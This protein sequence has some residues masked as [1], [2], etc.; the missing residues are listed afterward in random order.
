MGYYPYKARL[1]ADPSS[2]YARANMTVGKVYT[3]RAAAG[4][5]VEVS[6]N[7]PGDYTII[8]PC[9]LDATADEKDPHRGEC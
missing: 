9:W 2:D 4:S 1:V 8:N 6:T 3:V 7:I 5:C